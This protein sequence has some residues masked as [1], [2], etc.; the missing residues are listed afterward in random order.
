MAQK[1]KK[2][3]GKTNAGWGEVYVQN[4]AS[5]P[6]IFQLP[7]PHAGGAVP[8]VWFKNSISKLVPKFDTDSDQKRDKSQFSRFR[9]TRKMEKDAPQSSSC[10]ESSIESSVLSQGRNGVV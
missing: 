8:S 1:K 5:T 7:G 4:L 10:V 2:R 9:P 6:R 3:Y